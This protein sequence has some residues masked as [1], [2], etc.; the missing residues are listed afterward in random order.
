MDI[1]RKLLGGSSSASDSS[2]EGSEGGVELQALGLFWL[3]FLVC[4]SVSGF[5]CVV[6]FCV[7]LRAYLLACLCVCLFVC[8]FVLFCWL[9]GWLVGWVGG[10]VCLFNFFI[11]SG[12][13]NM[14][15]NQHKCPP[16]VGVLCFFAIA[17][18]IIGLEENSKEPHHVPNAGVPLVLGP[19]N[20]EPPTNHVFSEMQ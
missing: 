19:L 12:P 18:S 5:V 4:V 3:A 9:V 13:P 17:F 2:T 7:C 8:L 11:C 20:G 1:A 16:D 15:Q 10:W 6:W 14:D